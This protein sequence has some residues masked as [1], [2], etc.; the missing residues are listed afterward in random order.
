MRRIARRPLML[1]LVLVTPAGCHSTSVRF[2]GLFGLQKDPLSLALVA[3]QPTA[4]VVQALNPFPSYAPLQKALSDHVGRPVAVDVCFPFQADSGLTSGWYDLAV[5]TPAQYAGLT[6]PESLRVLA[7]P[8]DQQNRP[9]RSALLVVAANSPL[10]KISDLR[11]RAVAF[12]P[13]G[14]SRTHYAG[15]QLLESDG[16]KKADLALEVLPVPGTLKH[17]PDVRSVAQAVIAGGATAGFIDE[18]AWEALPEREAKEGEPARDKLRIIARTCALP[19]ALVVASAKLDSATAEQVQSFLLAAS[20][21]HPAVL[22]PL[23]VSGYQAP[24]A[25]LL[26]ACRS[27]AAITKGG[28]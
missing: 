22:Q 14:D 2:L 21:K 27:L 20:R 17:L 9:A 18:A 26:A 10:R 13:A 1:L 4:V 3:D 5:V 16:L 24:S 25:D 8:V 6:K 12:G 7:V 28:T 11:G 19:D 23:A 15:L